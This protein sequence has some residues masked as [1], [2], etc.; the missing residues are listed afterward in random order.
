VHGDPGGEGE[1][2]QHLVDVRLHI[3]RLE[4]IDGDEVAVA[5]VAQRRG[6]DGA[7]LAVGKAQFQDVR[8]PLLADERLDPLGGAPGHMRQIAVSGKDEVGGGH[9]HLLNGLI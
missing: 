6:D 5:E 8:K 9:P 2:S 7:A 3:P 4:T 1:R